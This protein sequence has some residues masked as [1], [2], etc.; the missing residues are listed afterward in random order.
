MVGNGPQEFMGDVFSPFDVAIAEG[1]LD[2]TTSDVEELM[3]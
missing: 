1:C 2:E 3:G